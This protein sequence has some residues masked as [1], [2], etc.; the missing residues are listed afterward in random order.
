MKILHTSDW[1][2][3]RSLYEK[4]R[5][6][7]FTK[8]LDWLILFIREEQV[9]V[10]LVAGDIFDTTTPN[11]QV[12][13]MYYRFLSDV[14]RTGCHHVVITGGNHD[15][16]SFLNAPREILR[17]L[18]VH[19]VGDITDNPEDEVLVLT[20]SEGMPEAVVCAVPYLRDRDVRTA[21]AG[22]S[23]EDKRK[24]L[25]EG[26]SGHYAAVARIALE[27]T[28]HSGSVPIIGMGHLFTSGGKTMEGDGVRELYVGTLAHIDGE[29][30]PGCFDYL[31][32]G[33]LH[34][35][36]KA[37]SSEF[38]RY[39]GSPIPM[40]F[41]ETGQQKTVIVVEFSGRSPVVTEHTVPCFR[42]MERICGEKAEILGRITELASRG[43]N[44]WI[45]IEYTGLIPADDLTSLAEEAIAGSGMEICRIKNRIISERALK[46]ADIEE[47]L[48]DLTET[49]VF[50]RLLDEQK[51]TDSP[52]R[53][54]LMGT[55]REILQTMQ[56]KDVNAD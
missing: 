26:I 27:K 43:S 2:L 20:N 33:H 36:Q 48:D 45:E 25:I 22:E 9:D 29:L 32:L 34:L 44:A 51:I 8:F 18:H 30:F 41:A 5:V 35:A 39:S 53:E 13:E 52:Q 10:L 24:K 50:T 28:G 3:G 56:E 1:H 14:T 42:E 23:P 17:A 19:V 46:Q 49:D 11:N 54:E 21:E 12:Q 31:A 7:E 15:S 37:G 38:K 6:D 40:G 47:T 55:F 4:K 16:P